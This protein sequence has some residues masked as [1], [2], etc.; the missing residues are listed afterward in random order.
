MWGT[1]DG[2]G[3]CATLAPMSWLPPAEIIERAREHGADLSSDAGERLGRYLSLL[4]DANRA[5]NLTA[6]EEVDTAWERHILDSLS[7][8]PELSDLAAG[9]EVVDV[10]SG[11]GLPALPLAIMLPALS[12]T[13]LEATGKKA[14]FL[15][16]SAKALDLANVSVV[17]ERAE[18]F[19]QSPARARFAAATARAVSRLPVL[20]E[21]TL[22]L[23]RVGGRVLAIK[24]EQAQQE[25][26][27]AAAALAILKGRVTQLRRTTTGTVVRVEKTAATPV[28]YPRRAGE[29]KRSPLR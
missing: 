22:P 20:L 29:P 13:L 4:L 27:E 26:D 21:L 18:A 6:I 25:V 15:R 1:F 7:L 28:H 11:G 16:D 8:L 10:G 24:G 5:F 17:S 19:G 14:Q 23:V 12:F 2:I 3:A 9:D